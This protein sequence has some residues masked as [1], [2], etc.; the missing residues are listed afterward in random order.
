MARTPRCCSCS[1]KCL[2]IF[3]LLSAIPIGYLIHLETT[4]PAGHVFEYY[5][6][7][8][9]R[10][11][12]K[13]D[14]LNGRFVV[15]FFDGGMGVVPVSSDSDKKLE[16]ITVVKE[17]DL[18]GNASLGFAIDG[19][20]NRVLVAIADM[21]GNKY[22][23]LAAYDLSTWTR[24]F[25]TQL[26]GP[27]DEKAFADDVAVDEEGNSYVTDPKASKIW[28]VGPNGEFLGTIRNP[29]FNPD[30]WAN[31]LVGLNGIVYHPNG[32]LLVIHTFAGKL[33]KITNIG[34]GNGIAQVAVELVNI[35]EGGS[36]K[37]GDG[38]QLLSPTKLV[39]AGNP[40]R[41]VEST[42]DWATAKVLRSIKGASHRIVTAATV[43]DDKV[44]LNHMFG[45]GYPKRKH[46]LLEAVF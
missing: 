12:S 41:L 4:K 11:C 7:G 28:K 29:L 45:L 8:W 21:F 35:V 26:S 23:A 33:Y 16:E 2:L 32:Y 31:K 10:E 24:I 13:W 42:D 30:G 43:K 37:F 3:F 14:H 27:D 40:T 44:Y 5:S 1:P 19:S 9:M 46:I 15:S 18:A 25:L 39:A 6:P 36:L 17:A 34:S 20:R 22:S 38:L